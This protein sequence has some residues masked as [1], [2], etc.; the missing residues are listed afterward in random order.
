M[1]KETPRIFAARL[2]ASCEYLAAEF[3]SV[4]ARDCGRKE[5]M[6]IF[7]IVGPVMIG[8]SS[9]HTAGACRLGLLAAGILGERPRQAEILLHGSFARTYKGHGTDRALVAGLMGWQPDD[10][11]I[12]NAL[13]LAAEAGVKFTFHPVDLGSMAHPNSVLF[14]LTGKNGNACE[15]I[16]AS[17]GGGQIM[18]TKVDGFP[19]ELTGVLPALFVPHRDEPGVIALVSTILAQKQINIASMR[20]FREGKGETAAMV[21]E[22]DQA[23]PPA[24]IRHLEELG[25]VKLVR[26]VDK[27][28]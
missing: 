11:R 26:F 6:N 25:P 4:A 9:S 21:I 7:D 17:V 19:V 13:K 28:S 12:P 15:V 2:H 10:V 3:S 8:P 18:V 22:C 14:R 27:V 16:G 23:V 5:P 20:V 1:L 24:V